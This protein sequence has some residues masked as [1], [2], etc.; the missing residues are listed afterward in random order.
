MRARTIFAGVAFRIKGAG[1]DGFQIESQIF[2]TENFRLVHRNSAGDLLQV[3]TA[4]NFHQQLFD[5]AEFI[6]GGKLRRVGGKG[7]QR[8]HIGRKPGEAVGFMLVLIKSIG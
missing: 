4:G 6:L 2:D 3:F 8:I 1:A 7:F 5:F